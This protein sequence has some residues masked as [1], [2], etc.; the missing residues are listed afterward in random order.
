MD[1][2]GIVE[3]AL[4]HIYMG[5]QFRAWGEL[6]PA[7]DAFSR[8][9]LLP[10]F[11]AAAWR[12]FLMLH[13]ED[14]ELDR[15]TQCGAAKADPVTCIEPCPM[16]HG[17]NALRFP[18]TF[19]DEEGGLLGMRVDMRPGAINITIAMY[20]LLDVAQEALQSSEHPKEIE[21]D[22]LINPLHKNIEIIAGLLQ[23]REAARR[24]KIS[25]RISPV[26]TIP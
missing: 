25:P 12:R 8:D 3:N 13:P 2:E 9:G 20:Y 10:A 7:H 23:Q 24:P 18:F 26:E 15:C 1:A 22:P 16:R 17:E 14:I 11:V 4:A 5:R 6:W 19:E 21:V